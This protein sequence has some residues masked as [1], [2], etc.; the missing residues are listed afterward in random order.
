MVRTPYISEVQTQYG[1]VFSISYNKSPAPQ[2]K[3]ANHLQN[4]ET[5]QANNVVKLT[6]LPTEV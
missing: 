3:T 2:P 4:Q 5:Y 6:Q 1:T